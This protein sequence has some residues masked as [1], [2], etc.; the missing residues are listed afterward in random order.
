MSESYRVA[1]LGGGSFG[2]AL[3]NIVADN[4]HQVRLWLRNEERAREINEQHRNQTYL[5]D[6]PLNPA[7]V[8]TA[9]LNA[10]VTECD[11]V[12]M[13][14]PSRSCREVARNVASR[15]SADCLLISTT[16]GIE[17]DG[18]HLMSQVL[19][20]EI[21]QVRLGVMSGPNLAKEIAARQITATVVAS[22]DEALI[23]VIQ[24]LL[25]CSYFRVYGSN[26]MYGVELGGALKNVYAIMAGM[27][28]AMGIGHNTISML[29]TRSLAE[30]SRFAV[31]LGAD[32]M[33]FLGLSGVGDLIV[34]CMSPLSRNYRVG[35]ELGQGRA[36]DDIIADL[37]QVA[38]GVNTL[39]LLKEEADRLGVR[40]PLVSGLYAIIY[41][42]KTVAA[43]VGSLMWA[44]QNRDV[45]FITR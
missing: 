34:T 25:H 38:E 10:A 27:A 9:D 30:M 26:D 20:E 43:V 29:L 35:F 33:T 13:A 3:A 15:L 37:G 6:F 22:N 2:T 40:M 5:P 4:G 19:A 28:A 21:P 39:R 12:F 16:K 17:P 42:R 18:F 24:A 11:I 45:E 31:K 41:E 32:P 7:L 1:V 8:A 23:S 44:E 14:V 36:L